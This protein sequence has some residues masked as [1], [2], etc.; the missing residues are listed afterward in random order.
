MRW[1]KRH[2]GAGPLHLLSMAACFVLAAYAASRLVASGPVTRIAVWFV[3]AAV[4]HDLVLW[5]L[6]ALA[7]RG[8]VRAARR[9]PSRLPRVPWINHVRVPVILAGVLLAV[10]FPL[11]LGLSE[12]NYHAFTGLSQAPFLGRWLLVTGSLFAASAVLYAVRLG[13]AR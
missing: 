5:P 12:R 1:L 11:V 3:G 6:Y 10:S 13:R 7:D 8:G 2:Y 9:D 4:A